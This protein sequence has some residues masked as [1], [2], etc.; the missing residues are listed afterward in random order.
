MI[1][2][3]DSNLASAWATNLL[4][5]IDTKNQ[6]YIDKSELESAFSSISGSSDSTTNVDDIFNQLDSNGDGKVT[7][8]EISSALAKI[9]QQANNHFDGIGGPDG[10]PPP[11]PPK[12]GDGAGFTKAE[13]VS[14]LNDI[15]S[16]DS[17]RSALI[18]DIVQNFDAADANGDGKVSFKEAMA[19]E[20]AHHKDASAS[21]SSDTT[22]QSSE[23]QGDETTIARQL[24]KLL[25]A[26]QVFQ[27]DG[28]SS[29]S[30]G[31]L[32]ISA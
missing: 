31:Q 32:S 9:L 27:N 30:T 12:E 5:K 28:S 18:S 6:G 8:S 10:P 21:T 7:E 26:Y 25:A 2:G 19:Y 17:K 11:P 13:L 15:G 22:T 1:S 23:S 14:Q 3:I 4:S 24:M 16:S 20:K 29:E